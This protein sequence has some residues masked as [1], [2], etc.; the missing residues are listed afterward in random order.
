MTGNSIETVVRLAAG[1]ATSAYPLLREPHPLDHPLPAPLRD[2][3]Q[4]FS[5]RVPTWYRSKFVIH[6][7]NT[8]WLSGWGSHG[9]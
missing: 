7:P 5:L 1:V 8:Y 6:E 4:S 3:H 9:G 2:L